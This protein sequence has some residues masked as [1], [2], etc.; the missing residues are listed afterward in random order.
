PTI[1]TLLGNDVEV[2]VDF[3][4]GGRRTVPALVSNPDPIV[5]PAP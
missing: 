3:I 2:L 4:G 1:V 5:A